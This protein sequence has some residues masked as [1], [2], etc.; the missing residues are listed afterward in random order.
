MRGAYCGCGLFAFLSNEE[1]GGIVVLEELACVIHTL[2]RDI[3][4]YD[5]WL[6]DGKNVYKAKKLIGFVEEATGVLT[7]A[8]PDLTA[9][10]LQ[11]AQERSLEAIGEK[12]IKSYQKENILSSVYLQANSSLEADDTISTQT[13][14]EGWI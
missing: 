10:G 2:V 12:L 4:V 13:R 8:L 11:I 6:S 5:D 1:T 14:K 7:G 3:P 9:S